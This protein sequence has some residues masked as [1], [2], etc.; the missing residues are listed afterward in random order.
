MAGRGPSGAASPG[1][2]SE[3]TPCFQPQDGT[4][5]V[6]SQLG[7]F[8]TF[9][10]SRE[11]WE[12]KC[13]LVIPNILFQFF[14]IFLFKSTHIL[15]IVESPHYSNDINIFKK[16][17]AERGSKTLKDLNFRTNKLFCEGFLSTGL[18]YSCAMAHEGPSLMKLSC[19]FFFSWMW[20]KVFVLLCSFYACSPL[21]SPLKLC[22]GNQQSFRI[23]LRLWKWFNS[24]KCWTT[25]VTYVHMTRGSLFSYMH[26]L[27]F[28]RLGS[29]FAKALNTIIFF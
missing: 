23:Y 13:V 7:W 1:A 25:S 14:F 28:R 12:K 19:L 18:I 27:C 20:V 15:T 6:S 8:H 2:T 16:N 11:S 4:W 22:E 3:D 5:T 24:G 29:S 9:V 10:R 26:S 17:Q 21:C